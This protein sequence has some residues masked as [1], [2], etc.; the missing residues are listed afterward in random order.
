MKRIMKSCWKGIKK[1]ASWYVNNY[2]QTYLV[3]TI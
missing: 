3:P 1:V 2:P